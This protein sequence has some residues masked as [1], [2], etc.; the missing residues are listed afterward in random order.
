[1]ADAKLPEVTP[2]EGETTIDDKVSFGPLRLSYESACALASK[3]VRPIA[4]RIQDQVVVIVGTS[5]LADFAN[6]QAAYL[7]LEGLTQEYS[8]IEQHARLSTDIRKEPAKG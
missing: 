6:L 4:V 5:V 2:L 7:T 8:S 1:M 3:I